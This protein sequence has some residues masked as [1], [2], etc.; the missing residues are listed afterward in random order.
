MGKTGLSLTG[1]SA[2][3]SA[4]REECRYFRPHSLAA[5]SYLRLQIELLTAGSLAMALEPCIYLARV[6]NTQW[7]V[8]HDTVA[9]VDHTQQADR[10]GL[11]R[12]HCKMHGRRD[13]VRIGYWQLCG[14]TVPTNAAIARQ[15]SALDRKA[16]QNPLDAGHSVSGER[17]FAAQQNFQVC[18]CNRRR[19]RE[20]QG[21]RASHPSTVTGG[22]ATK[23]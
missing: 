5:N 17:R 11:A 3:V 20:V 21:N 1:W 19:R 18:R 15:V 4:P 13:D 7:T 6:I 23:V 12:D 16:L 2:P 14:V 8:L 10:K 22:R 9:R